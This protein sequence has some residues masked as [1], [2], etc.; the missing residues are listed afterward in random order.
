[1]LKIVA[2]LA[3]APLLGLTARAAPAPQLT[4]AHVAASPVCPDG[5]A[6]DEITIQGGTQIGYYTAPL[7]AGHGMVFGASTTKYCFEGSSLSDVTFYVQA[8]SSCAKWN[9][10]LEIIDTETSCDHSYDRWDFDLI[11]DG[12]YQIRS[13]YQA[14]LCLWAPSTYPN[15]AYAAPCTSSKLDELSVFS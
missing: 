1:M 8:S 5:D 12:H 13:L 7:G 2:A 11:S 4:A 14:D 3:V 15:L 6:D 10:T 9:S